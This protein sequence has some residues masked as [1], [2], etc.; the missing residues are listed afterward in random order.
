ML[1]PAI[2]AYLAI[3][4]AAGFELRVVESLLRNFARFAAERDDSYV[5]SE[6]AIAWAALAPSPAQRGRRMATVV[7]FARQAH[8][9]D[10]QH[11]I[12]PA[13]VFDC[14][15][16]PYRPFIFS[17]DQIRQLLERTTQLRPI[18][19]LRPWTY[20]TLFSL[21][22]VTGLRIS[23]ALSLRFN[24]LTP[25]G[26]IV[27]KT[28]FRK[29]RLVPLHPSTELGLERYLKHRRQTGGADDHIFIS[30]RGSA[31]NYPTVVATFLTLVRELGLHPGP[32]RKGPRI[33]DLRHT[34]AVRAL[35]TCPKGRAEVSQHMLALSTYLGH[36]KLESTYLYL[37]TTPH[38]LS[39][40]A[41]D[42]EHFFRGATR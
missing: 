38:L 19:S 9:E 36:A 1:T 10:P 5:R 31:L 18:G 3:R 15:R 39:H 29:S 20:C 28:K 42:C 40:I 35:E 4:R 2:D 25:D 23:E 27:R 37:H 21:L 11:E 34:F 33:H 7:I 26:L 30:L 12:P 32:G 16:S 17:S 6:T 13:G 14:H 22:A 8:A 24:D 41:D